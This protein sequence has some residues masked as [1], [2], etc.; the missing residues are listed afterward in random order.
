M[1]TNLNCISEKCPV[2]VSSDCVYYTGAYLPIL[3]ILPNEE[4][5][6]ILKKVENNFQKSILK[7]YI[8]TTNYVIGAQ[9]YYNSQILEA[10]KAILDA[11][12]IIN[13]NDWVVIVNEDLTG[14]TAERQ[15]L[16]VFPSIGRFFWDTDLNMPLYYKAP[17]WYNT[18]G[19]IT[20]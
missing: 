12:T 3:D 13:Y 17:S 8:P 6:S 7:P 2:L 14:T 18:A 1:V 4:L 15:A 19:G 10:T 11:P 20:L 5:T 9:V 16:T